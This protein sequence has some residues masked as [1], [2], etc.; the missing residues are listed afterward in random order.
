MSTKKTY[1]LS[2]NGKQFLDSAINNFFSRTDS[3]SNYCR[4]VF[5]G[6]AGSIY[7]Y[8]VLNDC[9]R[10]KGYITTNETLKLILEKERGV[11][12]GSI[13]KF[14]NFLGEPFF[15]SHVE[16]YQDSKNERKIH[17]SNIEEEEIH[18]KDFIGRIDEIKIISNFL[19]THDSRPFIMHMYGVP[20]IGKTAIALKIAK[21]CLSNSID[22]P[23]LIYDSAI[24]VK[25]PKIELIDQIKESKRSYK[26]QGAIS[27]LYRKIAEVLD[28]E[29][30]NRSE[31]N[32]QETKVKK[33]LN[34][35]KTLLIIDDFQ[36]IIEPEIDKVINFINIVPISTK[37]IIVSHGYHNILSI[38]I[39]IDKMNEKDTKEFIKQE[40]F[41]NEQKF[42]GVRVQNGLNHV[43]N[44][45]EQ[46]NPGAIIYSLNYAYKYNE[47]ADKIVKNCKLEKKDTVDC[48]LGNIVEPLKG[49]DEYKLLISA[50]VFHHSMTLDALINVS[51]LE[52]SSSVE[53]AFDELISLGLINKNEINKHSKDETGRYSVSS[54]AREHILSELKNSSIF[55]ELDSRWIAYYKIFT[56]EYGGIDWGNWIKKY[57]KIKTEWLNILSV[58][59]HC[60]KTDDYKSVKEIWDNVNHF[61]DLEGFWNDRLFWL[62]YLQEKSLNRE[63]F[64][65]NAQ[66]LSRKAWTLFNLGGISNLESASQCLSDALNNLEKYSSNINLSE[67]SLQKLVILHHFAKLFLIQPNKLNDALNIIQEQETLL[68]NINKNVSDKLLLTR[69]KVNVARNYGEYYFREG[70]KYLNANDMIKKDENFTKSRNYYNSVLDMSSRSDWQRGRSIAYN[71]L[72]DIEVTY[73]KYDIAYSYLQESLKIAKH[74]HHYRRVA[75]CFYSFANLYYY[76]QDF[77]NASIRANDALII[78]KKLGMDYNIN[79]T[80]QLLAKMRTKK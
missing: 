52:K 41:R 19:S 20:G 46:G 75:K 38:K 27:H 25:F 18:S 44:L 50:S 14:F 71:C 78:F 12:K 15:D 43:N 63:D 59:E 64:E 35:Q 42:K 2:N 22:N 16:I 62:S 23:G 74:N 21:D 37:V 66:S 31:S 55:S 79:E 70:E 67:N 73:G 48:V 40:T 13:E 11:R 34:M 61:A 69:V 51:G 17:S 5:E 39:L 72:A 26:S 7:N 1:I 32:E 47:N 56:K 58:L 3:S 29:S 68:I 80:N 77:L 76:K 24:Y 57:G 49:K 9:L 54:S 60:A 30:I 53:I 36:N 33:A 28:D 10:E 6:R 65:T 4:R 8:F 45:I